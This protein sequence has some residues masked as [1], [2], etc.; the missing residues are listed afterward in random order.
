[1]LLTNYFFNLTFFHFILELQN[2]KNNCNPF[3]NL[4]KNSTFEIIKVLYL[5]SRSG[6]RYTKPSLRFGLEYLLPFL[7]LLLRRKHPN[8]VFIFKFNF[9]L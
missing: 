2:R 5:W 3:Q 4:I 9:P 7:G 6:K 8:I 1:M